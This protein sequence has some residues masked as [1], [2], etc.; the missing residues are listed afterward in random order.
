[1]IRI[2][3]ELAFYMPS[4]SGG[5]VAASVSAL[6]HVCHK[7]CRSLAKSF[8]GLIRCS[9]SFCFFFAILDFFVLFI[10]PIGGW[11]FDFR[12]I[13]WLLS[14]VPVGFVHGQFQHGA[15]FV[16]GSFHST[17]RGGRIC[18]RLPALSMLRTWQ[19]DLP[20]QC[21]LVRLRSR[22]DRRQKCQMPF[23]ESLNDSG[24]R[25]TRRCSADCPTVLG[26]SHRLFGAL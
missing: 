3:I 26:G 21:V 18:V 15:D 17:R 6:G 2:P 8:S 16:I 10:S 25:W 4:S 24:N 9:W 20:G 1:M 19:C 14:Q 23:R 11:N 13:R 5:S 22:G 12:I 7:P